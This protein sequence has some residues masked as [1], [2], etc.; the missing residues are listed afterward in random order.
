MRR[1]YRT[2]SASVLEKEFSVRRHL[3]VRGD[4]RVK[5][6]GSSRDKEK[7]KGSKTSKEAEE[8]LM[9]VRTTSKA[10]MESE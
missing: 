9:C 6:E 4:E 1:S 3:I 7:R 5:E 2:H 8:F 10:S